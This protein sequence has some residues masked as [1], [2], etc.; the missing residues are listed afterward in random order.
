V[1]PDADRKMRFARV[2]Q[3]FHPILHAL[4]YLL[5]LDMVNPVL[6]SI[7]SK[8]VVFQIVAGDDVLIQV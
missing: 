6:R 2:K 8:R 1:Y 5:E 7:F 3:L 4:R